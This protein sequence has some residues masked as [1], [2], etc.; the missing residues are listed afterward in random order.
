MGDLQPP[1]LAAGD[2]LRTAMRGDLITKRQAR[3]DVA[4]N[5]GFA[6][7]RLAALLWVIRLAGVVFPAETLGVFLLA[8]RLASTAAHL[9]QLGSS[10]TLLRCLPMVKSAGGRW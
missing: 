1:E 4:I 9:F 2:R 5:I 6:V 3:S 10:Q 8:R 7:I